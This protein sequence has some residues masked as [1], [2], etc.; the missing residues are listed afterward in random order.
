MDGENALMRLKNLKQST[1]KITGLETYIR[2]EVKDELGRKAW[3]N[4]IIT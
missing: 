2:I 1:Y 4:P 3:I